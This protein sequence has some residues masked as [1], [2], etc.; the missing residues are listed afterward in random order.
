MSCNFL[1]RLVFVHTSR[2][3]WSFFCSILSD[4]DAYYNFK[5]VVF[6]VF[7]F[8]FDLSPRLRFLLNLCVCILWEIFLWPTRIAIKKKQRNIH[9]TPNTIEISTG[10]DHIIYTNTHTQSI[11][12]D[13]ATIHVIY[14]VIKCID[15]QNG[16]NRHKNKNL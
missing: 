13:L 5:M 6:Y 4:F 14:T 11:R 2:W 9:L 8:F 1:F 3:C 10:L 7:F 16:Q 12:T 15:Q